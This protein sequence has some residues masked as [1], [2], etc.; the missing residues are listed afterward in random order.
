MEIGENIGNNFDVHFQFGDF[1]FPYYN[2]PYRSLGI[3]DALYLRHIGMKP[4]FF[5]FRIIAGEKNLISHN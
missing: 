5:N 1:C 3:R 2:L 4:R